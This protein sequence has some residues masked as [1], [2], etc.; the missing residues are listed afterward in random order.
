[1][2]RKNDF[3]PTPEF[4]TQELLRYVPHISGVISECCVGDGAIA[5]VIDGGD[6]VVY[7]SDIDPQMNCSFC[8]DATRQDFWEGMRDLMPEERIDWV[9]TNP[10][11][12]VA[13]QIVPLAYEFADKGIAMLLRLSFLEPVEDRGA[14]LNENPP[15]K[16]IVLPRISFTGNGKTDS[17]TCAWM[18]WEK[19][20]F[21]E[22]QIIVA[23]NPKFAARALQQKPEQVLF[24]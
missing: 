11:F 9:V 3:Y 20:P 24:A 10:P 18:V 1:M 6:R 19:A 14:W 17:V 12:N 5:R 7:G 22:K 8:G 13:A 4:G 23:E 21:A 15:T 16:L 2:R